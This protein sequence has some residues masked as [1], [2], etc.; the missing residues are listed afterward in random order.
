GFTLYNK[1]G[2]V[3][4]MMLILVGGRKRTPSAIFP[5]KQT[6]PQLEA[7]I[8]S[9]TALWLRIKSHLHPLK[10]LIEQLKIANR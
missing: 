4:S 10:K 1:Q 2:A 6:H 9:Y 5:T 3:A 7:I 8:D